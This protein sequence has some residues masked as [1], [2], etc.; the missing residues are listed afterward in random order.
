[1]AIRPITFLI[2][3]YRL[4]KFLCRFWTVI[5]RFLQFIRFV[6]GIHFRIC[7]FSNS[8][9]YW[10]SWTSLSNN[11]A[12]RPNKISRVTPH[13]VQP[14]STV[15]T[16][17]DRSFVL[18]YFFPSVVSGATAS[19][20]SAWP[21]HRKWHIPLHTLGRYSGS[22]CWIQFNNAVFQHCHDAWLFIQY[23]TTLIVHIRHLSPARMANTASPSKWT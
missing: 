18:K 23:N 6:I 10:V 5:N 21:Y 1:M 15:R 12:I 11:N 3:I 7:S 14:D 8:Y 16:S 19:I 2:S 22:P 20:S 13:V 9:R 4:L 17:V